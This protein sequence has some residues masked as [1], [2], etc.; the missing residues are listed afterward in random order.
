MMSTV[1]GTDGQIVEEIQFS[2][3]GLCSVIE[4]RTMDK[5]TVYT[6]HS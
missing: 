6:I 4:E 5:L 3:A 2:L 1:F